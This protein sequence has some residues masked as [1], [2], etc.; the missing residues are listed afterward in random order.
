MGEPSSALPLFGA[1]LRRVRAAIRL[2]QSALAELVGVDQATISRWESN[3]QAPD[4]SLQHRIFDILTPYRSDDAA[5]KRLVQS[6]IDC[7]HLV[8][9]ATHTCLAYSQSRAKDWRVGKAEMAGVSLWRFA[10]DEIRQAE[11]DLARTDWWSAI[12]P[13]PKRF[14]TSGS[15]HQEIRISAGEILWEGTRWI[16][17]NLLQ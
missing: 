10:T 5:L 15:D 8:D 11:H 17:G 4:P 2:K 7:I 9:E 13:R 6:S 3:A 12:A 16:Y 14:V 1:R